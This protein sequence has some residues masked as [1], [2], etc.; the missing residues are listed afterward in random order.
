MCKAMEK[1]NLK[2]EVT[3]AVRGMRKFGVSDDDIIK[4]VMEM[5]NVT[6][7]YVLDLMKEQM[8]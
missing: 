1:N 6:K 5:Y 8:A 4:A 7:E 2:R 3:G